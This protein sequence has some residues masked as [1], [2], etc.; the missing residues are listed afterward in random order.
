MCRT[1]HTITPTLYDNDNDNEHTDAHIHGNT[2]NNGNANHINT[3]MVK[4]VAKRL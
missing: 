2:N 3:K 1:T 4:T